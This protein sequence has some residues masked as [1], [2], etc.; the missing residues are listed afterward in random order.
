[1]KAQSFQGPPDAK[2]A[3]FSKILP[4]GPVNVCTVRKEP[5]T[6]TDLNQITREIPD[7]LHSHQPFEMNLRS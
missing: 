7:N 4:S 6:L 2:R 3:A 1:M 5:K